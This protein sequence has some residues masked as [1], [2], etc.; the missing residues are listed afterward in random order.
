[1]NFRE[2]FPRLKNVQCKTRWEKDLESVFEA[3]KHLYGQT[4]TLVS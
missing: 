1:M 2:V 4:N 3:F